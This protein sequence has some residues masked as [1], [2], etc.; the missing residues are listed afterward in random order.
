MASD[1]EAFVEALT[2]EER[3][4]VKVRDALYE[5]SW[6]ELEEDLRARLSGRPYIFKLAT[7]IEE[8]LGRLARLRT[9]EDEHDLDLA[10]LIAG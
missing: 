2:R 8:D 7:R 5:G 10:G 1:V 4:L 3:L 6:Q 9:F